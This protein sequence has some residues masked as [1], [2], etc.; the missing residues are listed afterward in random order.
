MSN[1]FANQPNVV[2]AKGD[3]SFDDAGITAD[4][5]AIIYK[6]D[7]PIQSFVPG[8][9]INGIS[10]FENGKGY[11][12][13]PKIDMDITAIAAPPLPS[14]ATALPAPGGMIA[15][16]GDSLVTVDWNTVTGATLYILDRAIDAGFTTGVSLA[17]YIGQ[18]LEFIDNGLTNGTQYFYRVRAI[19]SG[20][21]DSSYA[22]ANATPAVPV[23]TILHGGH[24]MLSWTENIA[25]KQAYIQ[26]MKDLGLNWIQLFSD[27]FGSDYPARLTHMMDAAQAKGIPALAQISQTASR[28]DRVNMALAAFAHPA[29]WK[30]NNKPCFQIYYGTVTSYNDLVTDLASAGWARN[31]YF[32]FANPFYAHFNGTSWQENYSS[33]PESQAAVGHALDSGWDGIIPFSVDRGTTDAAM[34]QNIINENT[35][36][37]QEAYS[38]G[39]IAFAGLSANY[40][41]AAV[42]QTSMSF[43][44]LDDVMNAMLALPS[45]QRPIGYCWTTMNDYQ[46]CSSVGPQPVPSSTGLSYYP[47]QGS[48]YVFG[49]PS[50]TDPT[51][52][53][54]G[55]IK[56]IAPHI[57]AARSNGIVAI[58]A[59]KMFAWYSLHPSTVSVG[60]TILAP[61]SSYPSQYTQSWWNASPFSSVPA[62]VAAGKYPKFDTI[63]MAAHL[64]APAKLKINGT[65][66]STTFGAGVAFFEIPIALGVPTFAIN[67]SGVDVATA[68]GPQTIVNSP[69]PGGWKQMVVEVIA[70]GVSSDIVVQDDFNYTASNL[71]GVTPAPIGVSAWAAYY[72]DGTI[73]ADG[74]NLYHTGSGNDIYFTAGTNN[75]HEYEFKISALGGSGYCRPLFKK[76]GND[77]AYLDLYPGGSIGQI[78]ST[79]DAS[80]TPHN[81]SSFSV[82]DIIIVRVNGQSIT[83]LQNGV[84]KAT[85]TINNS[86]TGN[87]I[88]FYYFGSNGIKFDYI[89]VTKIYP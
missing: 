7:N 55:A 82:N 11:Y 87:A 80:I 28:T 18:A 19:A 66:S 88:G 48:N 79:V 8:R 76:T 14:A 46:E 6:I 21:F 58:T 39:K 36:V 59:D 26:D 22:T 20:Y 57:A 86:L 67:R 24:T 35:W 54:T 71:I 3:I 41:N 2:L 85:A 42:Q 16:A 77:F 73:G 31:T 53:R 49:G 34:R 32:L 10:G 68:P 83:I 61:Y 62:W 43:S 84:Q 64:T 50:N 40:F 25:D 37:A 33:Y 5:V 27:I 56:F 52:D 12:L 15:T 75:A 9:D 38:R 70:G 45:A 30:I 89:K 81:I 74:A 29:C 69:V 4:N 23:V 78:I 1:V 63:R 13:I 51:L 65:L 60:S 72:N 47:P 17:L 44:A